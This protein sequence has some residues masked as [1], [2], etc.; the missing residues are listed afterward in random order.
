MTRNDV[1]K[2]F[3]NATE[4]QITS[5]LNSH[6]N[7]LSAEK[8]NAK[9][10]SNNSALEL[11]KAKEEV[12]KLKNQAEANGSNGLQKQIDELTKANEQA[13]KTIKNMELKAN[14]LGQGFGAEDVDLYIKTMDEGGDIASVLGKMKENAISAHDKARLEKTPE[15]Q[16]SGS[17]PPDTKDTASKLVSGMFGNSSNKSNANDILSNYKK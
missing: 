16:G 3:P 15:P 6:H 12:E 7:E 5:I 1:M 8:E 10:L 17:T 2:I 4:E 13:Q 9:A 11:A 14:L